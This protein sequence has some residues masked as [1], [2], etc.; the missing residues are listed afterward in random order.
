MSF[1]NNSFNTLPAKPEYISK[2]LGVFHKGTKVTEKE[3]VLR[4]GLTKTQALCA[5]IEL[6]KTGKV[7]K[8][9]SANSYTL[10]ESGE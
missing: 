5:L 6:I 2:V 10:I 3:L 1:P 9:G 7:K 8:D 4:S